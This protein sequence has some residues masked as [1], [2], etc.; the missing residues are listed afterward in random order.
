MS[1]PW[2]T[3]AL[4]DALVQS[5]G[6]PDAVLAIRRKAREAIERYRLTFGEPTVP[7]QIE[8]LAAL[9]DRSHPTAP[10]AQ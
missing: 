2:S 5:S 9:G 4:I 7:F 1:A 8:V 10:T 6:T 3:K